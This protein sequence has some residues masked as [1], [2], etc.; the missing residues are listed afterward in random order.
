MKHLIL[1]LMA[2]V[3]CGATACAYDK[4][5]T[6]GGTYTVVTS[7]NK[8]ELQDGDILIYAAICKVDTKYYVNIMSGPDGDN[9]VFNYYKTNIEVSKNDYDLIPEDLEIEEVNTDSNPYEYIYKEGTGGTFALLNNYGDDF[10]V[11]GLTGN[12]TGS[13]VLTADENPCYWTFDDGSKSDFHRLRTMMD[14][15]RVLRAKNTNYKFDTS[16]SGCVAMCY[17]KVA[18]STHINMNIGSTGFATMYYSDR[19]VELPDGMTAYTITLK[20]K[21]NTYKLRAN[22]IGKTVPHGTAVVVTGT[23]NTAFSPTLYTIAATTENNL[24]PIENNALKGTDTDALMND[25]NGKYYKL[26]DNATDGIGFYWGAADGVA[27]TNKAHKAYLFLP[28][29]LSQSSLSGIPFSSLL[30]GATAV[31]DIK[32]AVTPKGNSHMY[33]ISGKPLSYPRSNAMSIVGGRKVITR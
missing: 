26:A 20:K 2:F 21:G 5:T 1:S 11:K 17:K 27:F 12:K 30:D 22:N 25:G 32:E 14:G 3:L 28:A 23:A 4:L 16:S 19:D 8:D 7:V 13:Q 6:S 29:E 9:N 18:N 24:T 31:T 10:Y 15:Y 33:D